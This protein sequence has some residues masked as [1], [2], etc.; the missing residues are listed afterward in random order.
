ML[1]GTQIKINNG[2]D[3]FVEFITG[4]NFGC[5]L[6]RLSRPTRLEGSKAPG[7]SSASSANSYPLDLSQPLLLN[8]V[9][10][11]FLAASVSAQNEGHSFVAR[12]CGMA[13]FGACRACRRGLGARLLSCCGG[14]IV[15]QRLHHVDCDAGFR[16]GSCSWGLSCLGRFPRRR[17]VDHVEDPQRDGSVADPVCLGPH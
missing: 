13:A 16:D 1:S 17:V 15:G 7:L 6:P 2:R 12:C 10:A 11:F 14:V 4:A 9:L 8:E 5:I 3:F